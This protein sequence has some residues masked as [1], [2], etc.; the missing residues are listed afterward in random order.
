[1]NRRVLARSG[2]GCEMVAGRGDAGQ[3]AVNPGVVTGYVVTAWLF[4]AS[5]LVQAFLAGRGLYDDHDLFD[6]HEIVANLVFL[7]ALAQLVLAFLATKASAGRRMLI[8]LSTVILVLVVAQI[9]M[10]YQISDEPEA[11]AWHIL[12][13][14]TIFGLATAHGVLAMGV[15]R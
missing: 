9:A 2:K 10:G 11:G 15:R 7:L 4:V 12:N 1:M 5:V 6:V 13:G 14:V 8:G 3:G